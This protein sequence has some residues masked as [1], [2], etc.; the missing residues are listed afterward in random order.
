[1]FRLMF[2][3][4]L[5]VAAAVCSAADFQVATIFRTH[6]ILQRDR[7]IPVYGTADPG[8]T[9]KLD[10]KG[11]KYSAV[12][13]KNGKW[14]I[15]L[16]PMPAD[17]KPAN[18]KFSCGNQKKLYT[19]IVVGEVWRLMGQSHA[20]TSF[21]YKLSELKGYDLTYK[22]PKATCD[23]LIEEINGVLQNS[24]EDPLLR[25]GTIWSDGTATWRACSRKE[26]KSF[27]VFGYYVCKVLREE[28]NIPVGIVQMGRGSSSIESW[29]P[30]EYYDRPVLRDE[31]ANIE[32]YV[33]FRTAYRAKKLTDEQLDEFL[34]EYCKDP[35]RRAASFIKNGKINPA[36]RK[37][38]IF[39]VNAVMPT[40]SYLNAVVHTTPFPVRGM[41]WWQGE[42]NYYQ[43]FGDYKQKLDILFETYRKIWDPELPIFVILQ[44]QRK[45]YANLYSPARLQQ[46]QAVNGVANTYLVNNIMTPLPE[47]NLVHPYHEKVQSGKDTARL[48]LKHIY[49]KKDYIGSGPV[50]D[51]AVVKDGK[52]VVS[53]R[54][55]KGLKTSDGKAPVGFEVAGKD[56]KYFEAQAVIDGEKVVVSSDKVTA[57]AYVRFMWED[58]KNYCNLMNEEDLTAFPFDT[59]FEFFRK[60]N[61]INK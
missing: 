44:G 43:P 21:G 45:R 27:S 57:P 19:N 24:P 1:M 51:S 50:F 39:R 2:L 5:M 3:F 40:A 29:I 53:F 14:V 59:Q 4:C 33:K 31:K 36:N 58:V 25:S 32:K 12:A 11:K 13:D 6:M 8:A 22:T 52:F 7:V 41:F 18:M 47:I 15:E 30:E 37:G 48:M 23:A 54:F 46:F 16:P 9:V 17:G 61:A 60:P 10:F 38:I 34:M 28:L 49:G 42:T 55:A 56:K 26:I 35:K 20:A